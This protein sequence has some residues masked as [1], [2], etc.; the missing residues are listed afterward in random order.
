MELLL[1]GSLAALR[2]TR[3][4]HILPQPLFHNK[5]N[6][7]ETVAHPKDFIQESFHH[8]MTGSALKGRMK[9]L[10]QRPGTLE[11]SSL[12]LLIISSLPYLQGTTLSKRRVAD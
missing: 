2:V 8:A 10:N 3:E 5:S 6:M 9:K 7:E 12:R 1:D 4:V 11:E